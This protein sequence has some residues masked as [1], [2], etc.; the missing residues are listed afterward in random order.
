MRCLGSELPIVIAPEV[1][2]TGDPRLLTWL[3]FQYDSCEAKHQTLDA[4]RFS[5]TTVSVELTIDILLFPQV[6]RRHQLC[7]R[8][9]CL[10]LI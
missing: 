5:M 3:R 7:L 1:G 10:C 9:S 6:E 2:P 4:R 8:R